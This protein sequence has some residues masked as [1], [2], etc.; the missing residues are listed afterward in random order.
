MRNRLIELLSP[1]RDKQVAIAAINC[2]A[3][4]IYIGPEKFGARHAAGNK[5]SDIEEV[6]R[7]AHKYNVK[8]YVTFNTILYDEELEMAHN[9]INALYGIGID[10]LI[11][12]DFAMLEM[13]LPP[14]PLFASTQT[15]NTDIKKIKFLE[16]IGLQRVILARELTIAQVKEIC[17]STDIEIETFIH[18]SLC[19]GYSGQCSMSQAIASRS[20]NRGECAQLCRTP[21]SLY[22]S[23]NV[24][25]VKNKH[26]L[27]IKD[28]NLSDS[29]SKLIEAGVNS[30]KIE[31][32]LKDINYVKN[33]TASYRLIIDNILAQDKE[34]VKS[35]SG[36][37]VCYF[38]PDLEKTFNRNFTEY[39]SEG[40]K[41]NLLEINS[42]KSTG[43]LIGKVVQRTSK[44]ITI[45]TRHTIVNGDGLCFFN[46]K[47]ELLG[48][49]VNKVI[50]NEVVLD[51]SIEINAGALIYRNFDHAFFKQLS[52]KY[53]ERKVLVDIELHINSTDCSLNIK[54]ENGNEST[55]TFVVNN[56]KTKDIEKLKQII[57]LNLRKTGN[58]IFEVVNIFIYN[59]EDLFVPVSI[60]AEK[61]R[62][63]FVQ[64]MEKREQD[65]VRNETVV[66]KNNIPFPFSENGYRLNVSNQLAEQFYNRHGV[67]VSEWAVEKTGNYSEKVLMTTK[68]CLKYELGLCEKYCKDLSQDLAKKKLELRSMKNIFELKF[69]C[70][71]C[72]MNLKLK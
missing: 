64:L 15:H 21:L 41:S 54:D 70:N 42:P 24:E 66:V 72:T 30:F 63:A 46:S 16:Q 8:T 7:Y 3:D 35:S 44:S 51:T 60:I 22:T 13:G 62:E 12:Q 34:R 31:G 2:G 43:K 61:R 28:L 58:T 10:A 18:G 65:Y 38:T 6:V 40:R 25:I 53:A 32:R 52:G 55:M 68:M 36:K 1:A 27:S 17:D 26:L 19:V 56:E 11:I 57:E 59:K 29:I 14:I 9:Y 50:D 4:A 47:N 39:F 67:K 37:I 23:E 45:D 20:G 5:L 69:D 71:N 48:F 49:S 33:V